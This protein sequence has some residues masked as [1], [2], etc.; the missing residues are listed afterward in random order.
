MTIKHELKTDAP[1]V[2]QPAYQ[3]PDPKVHGDVG[4]IYAT[5]RDGHVYAVVEKSGEVLWK[6]PTTEPVVE[7]PAVI[8]DRV[9]VPTQLGGMFCL[10]A[11]N[12]KQYWWA[13]DIMHFVAASKQRVYGED[14]SGQTIVLNAKTSTQ[15]DVLPTS[16]CRSSCSNTETDRLYLATETGLVQC[17]HEIELA[18]P[19]LYEESRRPVKEEEPEKPKLPVKKAGGGEDRPR[20]K[21]TPK[22]KAAPKDD[23][24]AEKPAKTPRSRSEGGQSRQGRGGRR[25]GGGGLTFLPKRLGSLGDDS[26]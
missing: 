24:D 8:E 25:S 11:K 12:G 15:F 21:A 22:P 1:I 9:Y 6:F 23:A 13:P 19:L 10:N 5:S 18:K 16:G 26:V 7:P 4:V 20:P 3:P 2:S 17:L 14:R